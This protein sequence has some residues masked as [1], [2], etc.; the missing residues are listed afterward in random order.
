MPVLSPSVRYVSSP[1]TGSASLLVTV[2]PLER[3][4]VA[5]G[6]MMSARFVP[7]GS[8]LASEIGRGVPA[9]SGFG[10]STLSG[11]LSAALAEAASARTERARVNLRGSMMRN[12]RDRATERDGKIGRAHV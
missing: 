1:I 9:N 6:T 5:A 8:R 3:S 12:W 2:L 7:A 10:Y 4:L 11:T